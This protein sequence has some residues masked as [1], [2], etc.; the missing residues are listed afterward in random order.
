MKLFLIPMKNKNAFKKSYS[1]QPCRCNMERLIR[2]NP[3][4]QFR[5]N[6]TTKVSENLLWTGWVQMEAAT[7]EAG[8]T[9]PK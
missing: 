2:N 8:K 5:K 7:K 3:P 1:Q 6:K 4:G 9:A